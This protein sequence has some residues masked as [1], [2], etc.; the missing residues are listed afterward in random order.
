LP[1]NKRTA[2][3]TSHMQ[4]ENNPKSTP[5]RAVQNPKW[6][7]PYAVR[8][9]LVEAKSILFIHHVFN[10]PTLFGKWTFPGGRL[11]PDEF[12]PLAALHREMREELSV[13]IEV[14]GTLGVYYSR[15]G[16]DYAIFAARPLGPLGPLKTD[17]IRDITWLTPAE[18]Y[19][20]YTQ[21]KLQ[22]GFEM[23]AVSAYLKLFT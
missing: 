6:D 16:M 15:A 20:W 8:A 12:D 10:D 17:E 18:V 14:L 13:D 9:V 19:E 22:F 11:D 1:S 21:E 4:I 7:R 2:T 3:H 5:E 23:K